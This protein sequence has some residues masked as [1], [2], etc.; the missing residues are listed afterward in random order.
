MELNPCPHCG[1]KHFETIPGDY[2]IGQVSDPT[3]MLPVSMEACKSCGHL[4]IK[5]L[6]QIELINKQTSSH[7]LIE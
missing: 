5:N 7:W 3:L 2:G 4:A 6:T 1:E